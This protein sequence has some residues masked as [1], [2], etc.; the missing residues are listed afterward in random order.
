MAAIE[1]YRTQSVKQNKTLLT[2]FPAGQEILTQESQT[3]ATCIIGNDTEASVL[4]V[5]LAEAGIPSFLIGPFDQTIDGFD[6]AHSQSVRTRFAI[7]RLENRIRISSNLDDIPLGDITDL[8]ITSHALP[9][10]SSHIEQVIR[11]LAPELSP[12]SCLIYTGL[13]R[14][15]YTMSVVRGNLETYSGLSAGKE[16]G[17][18]YLPL[19][20]TRE[21]L[22]RFR[23]KPKILAVIP[24][25][26]REKIDEMM[27]HV[28]PSIQSAP[29]IET[30]EAAGL[31]SAASHEVVQGLQLE[32]ALISQKLGIDFGQVLELCNASGS[33]LLGSGVRFEPKQPIASL[34]M[35]ENQMKNPRGG[36]VQAAR[37]VNDEF[38]E[39]VFRMVKRAFQKTGQPIRRS[40]IAIIG[41]GWLLNG[42]SLEVPQIVKALSRKCASVTLYP[43]PDVNWKL[44]ISPNDNI[45]IETTALR[46]LS[47]ANCALVA[48]PS[49]S[50]GELD[51]RQ[52]AREMSRPGSICDI[53]GVMIASNV[54]QAGLFYTTLGRGTW[55][56]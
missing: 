32:L 7:H 23:E 51:A 46:A 30:A 47:H 22:E 33:G 48:L 44:P 15:G 50:T 37:K 24:G 52:M 19:I 20:W 18:C 14:P 17:L 55:T 2:N 9:E 45:R 36:I 4:S 1:T 38:Q 11:R 27:L 41:S 29:T 10:E 35:A 21:S 26:K 31:Y 53:T 12:G 5:L 8:I 43:G 34:I 25:A 56:T 40:K 28:F 6:P 42:R 13:C 54:E 49:S 16:I 3:P 39:E